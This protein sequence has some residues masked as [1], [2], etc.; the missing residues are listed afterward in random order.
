M[1]GGLDSFESPISSWNASET[2]YNLRKFITDER[3]VDIGSG[4]TNALWPWFRYGEVLLNY[5]EA[6]YFL[7]NEAGC[8]EYI[9]MIRN[10]SSVQM[11]P[12]YRK[13]PGAF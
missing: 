5:A 9:N 1:P 6:L 2:G 8:R 4:N 13:R 12:G 10:R 3:L 7:G 11:P